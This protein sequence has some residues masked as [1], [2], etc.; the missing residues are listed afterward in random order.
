MPRPHSLDVMTTIA[1]PLVPRS[2]PRRVLAA[3]AG[4]LLPGAWKLTER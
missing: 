3:L 1:F 2:N 4:V